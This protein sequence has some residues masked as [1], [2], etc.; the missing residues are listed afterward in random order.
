MDSCASPGGEAGRAPSR[1]R[2]GHE[3]ASGWRCVKEE[4][5]PALIPVFEAVHEGLLGRRPTKRPLVSF[6]HYVSTKSTIRQRDGRYLMRISDHLHDAPDAAIRGLMGILLCRAERLPESRV[7]AD[8]RAAYHAA[9]DHDAV[10]ERRS[11][12]RKVR[13]RKVLD[14]VGDHRS[15]L[16]SYLRVSMQMDLRLP[17]APKLSWSRDRTNRRFGHQDT[18]HDCIVISRTLDDPNVPEFVL[19]YVVYH[20]LLHI[21]IPPR[22]GR[23]GR[24]IVHPREFQQAEAKFPERAEAERWLSKLASRR[25]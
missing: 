21:A 7:N 13:G 18:D 19:D 6:Y 8:D 12:S 16:E 11:S 23:G 15:L 3:P 9:L 2:H 1:K 24:R 22:R 14:P 5:A 10:S 4:P 25:R 20:E 17:S